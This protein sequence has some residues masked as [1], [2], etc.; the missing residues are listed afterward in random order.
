MS[1]LASGTSQH[2]IVADIIDQLRNRPRQKAALLVNTC[3][4]RVLDSLRS[5]T[6]SIDATQSTLQRVFLDMILQEIRSSA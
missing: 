3:R 6:D 5:H 2:P 4:Q 1:A